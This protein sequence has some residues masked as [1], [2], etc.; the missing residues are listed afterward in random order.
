MPLRLSALTTSLGGKR[1]QVLF[2]AIDIH[3]GVGR[4]SLVLPAAKMST[5]AGV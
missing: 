3:D 1:G 4:N 2:V 5:P